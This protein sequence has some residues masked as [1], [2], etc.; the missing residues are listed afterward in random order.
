MSDRRFFSSSYSVKTD[1]EDWDLTHVRAF[2][3]TTDLDVV[4]IADVRWDAEALPLY[5]Y[6]AESEMQDC[7]EHVTNIVM[8]R[9]CSVN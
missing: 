4:V 6:L 1:T 8:R 2:L 7:I 3:Q 5:V 9:W